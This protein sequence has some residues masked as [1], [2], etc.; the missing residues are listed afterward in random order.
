MSRQA[1]GNQTAGEFG[2]PEIQAQA[3]RPLKD[4]A[5]VNAT[6]WK[7]WRTLTELGLPVEIGAGGRTKYN[8][9]D[10]GLPKT[11]WLDAVCVGPGC[12]NVMGGVC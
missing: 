8:R 5:A 1:K 10:A 9:T 7:P 12:L 6:R 11:H 2:H 4:A 3:K